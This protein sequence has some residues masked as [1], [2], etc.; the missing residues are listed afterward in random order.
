MTQRSPL[1]R[2]EI[3]D[4]LRRGTVPARGLADLAVGLDRLAPRLDEELDHAVSG[5]AG[6]KAIR[7]DYGGGKTFLARWLAERAQQRGMA[8]SEVQVSESDTPLHRLETVYRRLVERLATADEG[9]AALRSIIA[10]WTYTLEEEV[11]AEGAILET[12]TE[13]LSARVDEL[14][15]RRLLAVGQ[16]ASPFA[17]ALRGYRRA[18]A[19]GDTPTAEGLLAWLSGQPNVAA[20]VKKSAGVK[21]ELDH[22]GALASLQAL[23]VVLREAGHPGLLLVLDEVETLQRMRSDVRN[24]GLNA[25]RQL[26]DEIDAGRFPGLYLVLTGTPAFFEGQQG[27][28]R[29][30]PLAQRLHTSFGNDPRFD[31]S[32]AVQVRLPAFD[33]ARLV[34]VGLRVRDIYADGQD[35]EERIGRLV[36]DRFVSDLAD[37]VTGQLGAQ[38]GIAPRLFLKKLVGEVLDRVDEFPEFDPRTDGTSPITEQELSDEEREARGVARPDDI[39]LDLP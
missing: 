36:D 24:K 9:E 34:E 38:V 18:L 39:E 7:A 25:L 5:G 11:L 29:L 3:V 4:A 35:S 10:R 15:E 30:A 13:A 37:E 6:F 14:A 28:Q 19:A 32:R 21:G 12:D 1:R 2:R 16:K 27:V 26:L 20:G 17:A 22:F 23:L 8:T 33:R 31:S